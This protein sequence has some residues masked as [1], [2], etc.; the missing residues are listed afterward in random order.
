MCTFG[1]LSS[2]CILTKKQEIFYYFFRT[3]RLRMRHFG[4]FFHHLSFYNAKGTD[5]F[6]MQNYSQFYKMFI[7]NNKCF[8]VLSWESF[9]ID[10]DIFGE[11]FV[12]IKIYDYDKCAFYDF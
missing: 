6:N 2:K 8:S 10:I 1:D 5:D 12:K 7:Y 4:S 11:F 3:M 9:K